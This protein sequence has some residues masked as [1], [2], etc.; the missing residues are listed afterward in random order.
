MAAL[1]CLTMKG[2]LIHANSGIMKFEMVWPWS[3]RQ[4]QKCGYMDVVCVGPR[5]RKVLCREDGMFCIF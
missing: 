2:M 3:G 1:L 4:K 5:E